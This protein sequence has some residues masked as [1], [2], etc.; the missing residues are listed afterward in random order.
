MQEK[1]LY[2]KRAFENFTLQGR[3]I[4]ITEEICPWK[5]QEIDSMSKNLER[6]KKK[7]EMVP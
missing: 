7:K 6:E 5:L 1:K 4:K 3:I 2:L